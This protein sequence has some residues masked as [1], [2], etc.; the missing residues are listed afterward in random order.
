VY[1]A[2]DAAAGQTK[3]A[4]CAACHNADGNSVNP[5]WPKLAGQSPGYIS[6]QLNDFKSGARQN[7]T[8]A[9][10]AAPLSEADI[11]DL[12][13][14]FS[15]QKQQPGAASADLVAQGEA[16]YRAGDAETGV[17]A[18]TAC[19]GPTGAGNPAAKFPRVSGQ[20]G[21]YLVGQ[22]QAF[23]AGTRANDP[24]TMM[25]SIASRMT[26]AQMAA[27]ADYMSGLH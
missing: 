4:T 21:K 23:K 19:H 26:D 15:A 6:K 16:I 7:A 3:A 27:V 2:G 1:A 5:D 24:N 10:M 9:P 22:L 25:R 11:A 18:C 20:H 14:Y 12:A 17:A 8:M 13:A